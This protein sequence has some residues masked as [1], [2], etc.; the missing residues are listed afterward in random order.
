MT[1]TYPA[2]TVVT[3]PGA[4][5]AEWLAARRQGIGGSDVAAILGLNR[6]KTPLAIWLDKTT[7]VDEDSTSEAAE[8]GNRIEPLLAA[9]WDEAHPHDVTSPAPGLVARV[10]EPWML[11]TP[12]RLIYPCCG[13]D[14]GETHIWEG[15]TAGARQAHRWDDD[16]MPDEYA[17]QVRWYMTVTGARRGHVSA[18]IAG[19][20]YVERT[21]EADDDFADMLIRRVADWWGRHIID[22]QMPQADPERDG[23]LLGA[24]W[25]TLDADRHDIS[26]LADVVSD[27]RMVRAQMKNLAE[28]EARYI[29]ELKVA[30]ADH[31]DGYIGDDLAITWRASKPRTSFDHKQLLADDPETHA[32]YV[33]A[34]SPV[35]SFLLKESK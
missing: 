35:R 18:L 3:G 2:I 15:K 21:L 5:R 12:D 23:E 8:W 17:I 9:R 20:K 25:T 24:L 4:S 33:R 30:M 26:D 13:P 16:A 14:E 27:L 6:Y 11:A 22:G 19:Q 28:I 10:D 32:R 1:T 29:A 34:G 31:T 7:E